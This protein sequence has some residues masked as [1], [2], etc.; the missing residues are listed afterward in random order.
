MILRER[1]I[2]FL[3][4]LLSTGKVDLDR[5]EQALDDL[6]G[7]RTEADLALVVRSLPPPLRSRR[8][9]ADAERH[10]KSTRP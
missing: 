3:Q 1:G 8:L 4:G 6:L 7:A 10:S 9:L 2:N 5:F